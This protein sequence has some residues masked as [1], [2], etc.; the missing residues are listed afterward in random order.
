[1]ILFRTEGSATT[2]YGHLVRATTLACLL[3]GRTRVVFSHP[4]DKGTRR[5]LAERHW[6]TL[7]LPFSHPDFPW[8]EIRLV[9]VD[10]RTIRPEEQELVQIARSRAIPVVQITDMGLSPLPVTLRIDGALVRPQPFPDDGVEHLCGPDWMLLPNR[11]LHF[12][13]QPHPI[14]PRP[15]PILLALGSSASYRLVESTCGILSRQGYL[16][17]LA[18]GFTLKPNLIKALRRK[19]PGLR[20]CG[21]A[22]AMARNL[23]EA[24]LAL[25]APGVTAYEAAATG[26]PALYHCHHPLQHRTAEAFF[27]AGCGHVLPK[28]AEGWREELLMNLHAL[29]DPR[30]RQTLSR[31]GQTLVDARGTLRLV[32]L[33]EKRGWLPPP[34]RGG[35]P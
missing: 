21:P 8:P 12:S 11:F 7:P 4:K 35:Q 31:E 34:P 13:K 1:M 17:K 30:L 14:R 3:K 27:Q 22:D 20:V 23:F 16:I 19:V 26:T 18:P 6:R 28:K 5:F 29:Q 33:F 32:S 2:G 25:L 15:R 9:L 24:D 10:I